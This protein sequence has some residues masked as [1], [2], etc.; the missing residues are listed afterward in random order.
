MREENW[1]ND[2]VFTVDEFLTPDECENYIHLSEDIG[3]EDALV[4]SPRG[5]PDCGI[6][7]E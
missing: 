6:I 2:F 1:L 7:S 5:F 3:Y 4:T